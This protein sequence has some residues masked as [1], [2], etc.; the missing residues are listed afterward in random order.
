MDDRYPA[1]VFLHLLLSDVLG[2]VL[3]VIVF[4]LL[5]KEE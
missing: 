1:G 4:S 5:L 3:T 2:T